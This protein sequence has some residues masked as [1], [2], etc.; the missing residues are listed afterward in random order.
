MPEYPAVDA[1]TQALVDRGWVL[2][3]AALVFFMQAGFKCLEVGLTQRKSA[4]SVAMKNLIDW[5]I[6]NLFFFLIGFGLM[7]GHSARGLVGTDLFA[8]RGLDAPAGH[9]LGTVFFLFQL[10]FA[11]TSTTI[12]SG[13]MAERTRFVAYLVGGIAV[14]AII[15]PVFGHW[16]WGGAFFAGQAGWL[17][18]LGFVDFAGSTVVHSTGAWVALVGVYLVGPRQGRFDRDGFPRKLRANSPTYATLGTLIL[19][20][21]WWGFNGGSTLTLDDRVGGIVLNTNLAAAMGGL[22]AFA[23]VYL[24]PN[25]DEIVDKFLG[26]AL[27]GL[28]AITAGCHVVGPLGA[29]CIGA[30][31]GLVHNLAYDLLLRRLRVDDPVSAIPVHGFCGALGTLCVAL[32]GRAEALPHGRLAQLGV[33]ALG[34]VTC[35]AWAAGVAL[36]MYALLR[37]TVGLRVTRAEEEA[38]V[39][40]TP[41]AEVTPAPVVPR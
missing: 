1:S 27:G 26:G 33:Q 25:H 29:L 4:T 9:T 5:V 3:S 37:R 19:W 36:P 14:S 30:L 23:H 2:I 40:L 35:F 31:A 17:E 6:A 18:R 21:G 20:L 8:L 12:I 24:L 7:F 41:D 39:S 28:V 22:V 10:A 38:G 11:G 34:A 13:A 16:A 15:Y 32:F